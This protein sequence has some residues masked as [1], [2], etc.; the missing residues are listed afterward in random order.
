MA[1]DAR[2]A[3]ATFIES[4]QF[5]EFGP[6]AFL[7]RRR[8]CRTLPVDDDFLQMRRVIRREC[9]SAAGVYGFVDRDGRLI[10]VGVSC[11]LRKRLVTYFQCG[12]VYRKER[13]IAS[14]ARSLVWEAIGHDF[15]AQLRELELIRRYRPRFNV[16]GREEGRRLG[17]IYLSGEE[18]PRLRVARH[19]PLSAR[20]SWGPLSIGSWVRQA[21]EI[22]NL[23][24][25]LCDCPTSVA[26][27]FAD[28]RL[29][30][31]ETLRLGCLRGE[32]GT[33]LGP[34]AGRCSQREYATQWREASA[35]LEGRSDAV[36]ERLRE[37]IE[38]AAAR[39]QYELA[40]ALRDR[41]DYLERLASQ[42]NAVRS[43]IAVSNVIYPTRIGRRACWFL[44]VGG[45]VATALSAP[46]SKRCAEG[47]LATIDAHYISL[48]ANVMET[49]RTAAAIVTAWFRT[50]PLEMASLLSP[51]QARHK[52]RQLLETRCK[53]RQSS[54][55]C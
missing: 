48:Y 47:T 45:I 13:R 1:R 27:R 10:Y 2:N 25:K 11:R 33:C 20:R 34:C 28:Q 32:I 31:D 54:T 41:L 5:T 46:R 52:C 40:G 36:K 6:S 12:E 43:P 44:I 30:F 51:D 18:A 35:F 22:V 24:F 37:R 42:L 50:H 17:Y 19:P 3:D 39:R 7:P 21:V 4:A 8:P 26:M 15:V 29:L 53:F 14:H 49:N 9:P 38:S 55:T 16:R 23:E